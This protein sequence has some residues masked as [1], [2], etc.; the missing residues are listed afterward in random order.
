[1]SPV[2][3]FIIYLLS[4]TFGTIK[5]NKPL[6]WPLALIFLLFL[7]GATPKIPVN[8]WLLI[9]QLPMILFIYDIYNKD[10]FCC[11]SLIKIGAISNDIFIS[12]FIACYF[13]INVWNTGCGFIDLVLCYFMVASLVIVFGY[14]K[15]AR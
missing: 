2:N 9:W 8:L 3:C 4:Y 6:K 12:H 1:M 15:K 11:S 7:F 14:L 5:N 10:I 13:F